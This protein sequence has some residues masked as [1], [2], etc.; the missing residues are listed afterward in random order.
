MKNRFLRRRLATLEAKATIGAEAIDR[1]RIAEALEQLTDDELAKLRQL[2]AAGAE[3]EISLQDFGEM[4]VHELV[5]SYR[6][7]IADS[8][9][10]RRKQR[11]D[12]QSD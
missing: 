4:T 12:E 9:S 1:N 6:A 2:V 3:C 11:S 5:A 10:D 8:A 7:M